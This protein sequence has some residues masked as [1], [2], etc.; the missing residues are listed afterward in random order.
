MDGHPRGTPEAAFP[1]GQMTGP[2]GQMTGLEDLLQRWQ[3]LGRLEQRAFLA[4]VHEIDRTSDLVE[5]KALAITREFRTIA[6]SAQDQ[7]RQMQTVVEEAQTLRLDGRAITMADVTAMIEATS[8]SVLETIGEITALAARVV[9][10]LD[11]VTD[12]VAATE[13]SIQQIEDINRKTNMLALNATIEAHRA[14]DA[15]RT[16][17][18]VA[19]EVRDLSRATDKLAI[20]MRDQI[21]QVVQGLDSSRSQL[22]DVARMDLSRHTEA[23][24]RLQTIMQAL[25][26]QA[27]RFTAALTQAAADRAAIGD[28]VRGLVQDLQFQDRAKQQLQLVTETLKVLAD[29]Q[30]EIGAATGT[31]VPAGAADSPARAW[32]DAVLARIVEQHHLGEVQARFIHTV[33]HDGPQRHPVAPAVAPATAPADPLHHGQEGSIELF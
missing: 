25:H 28:A 19:N 11:Q 26:H 16:F 21:G 1:S 27:D 33:L 5:Q 23:G 13:R 17:A 14:G 6:E 2:S 20:A 3:S 10:A 7:T 12:S 29:A 30:D 15:G 24:Q 31:L 4:L 18:V 22:G 8:H 32:I 9:Q